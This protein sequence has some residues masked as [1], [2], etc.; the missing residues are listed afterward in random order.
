MR[1]YLAPRPSPGHSDRTRIFFLVEKTLEAEIYIRVS[2]VTCI[3]PILSLEHQKEMQLFKF[4]MS[5]ITD[6]GGRLFVNRPKM[7]SYIVHKDSRSGGKGV[8]VPK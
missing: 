1:M 5:L 6:G 2:E 8:G 4:D 7:T 3:S